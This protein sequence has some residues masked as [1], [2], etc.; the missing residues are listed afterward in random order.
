MRVALVGAFP[1]PLPQGSQIYVAE[2]SEA[3]RRAGAEPVLI[4]YREG[5]IRPSRGR[6]GPSLA[7]PFADAALLW[8][9]LRAHWRSPV[10]VVLAHNAEAAVVSIAARVWTGVP[11]LYVAHT[12]LRYE[13]SAYAPPR[14]RRILDAIGGGIDAWIARRADGIL[15]LS[16]DSRALLEPHARC[17]IEVVPPGLDPADPPQPDEQAR[18][19]RAAEVEPG[20]FVL[21]A[22]NLDGYQD[23]ELLDAA[24]GL[25]RQEAIPFVVAT[26]EAR[27]GTERFP[28]LRIVVPSTFAEIRALHF[29][30][31]TLVLTR[32]RPGGFP[33]KLLNY[34]EAGRAIVAF[35]GIAPGLQDRV[36]A[37][38]LDEKSGAE[39]LALV[40]RELWKD[41]EQGEQLGRAART[42]LLRQ[43]ASQDL[44]ERTLTFAAGVEKRRRAR[45][46]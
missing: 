27:N 1:F 34:M 12:I 35:A 6:S 10:D 15:A 31:G 16:H 13:L 41:P 32:R 20:R 8:A 30:A 22:G 14:W 19:C 40:I 23:L 11:V 5:A 33:I 7:K 24:A 3:L 17:P 2:Q 26:H 25:C 28:N 9:V 42:H 39:E 37:R 21:Y 36:N 18:A 46:A 4:T 44:A 38:L 43:H 29:A 45:R